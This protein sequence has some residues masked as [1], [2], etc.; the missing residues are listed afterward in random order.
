MTGQDRW[1]ALSSRLLLRRLIPHDPWR[2]HERCRLRRRAAGAFVPLHRLTLRALA[3]A[4]YD[5][6]DG[7]ATRSRGA[8]LDRC[9]ERAI[10]ELFEEQWTE[11][12]L[13]MPLDPLRDAPFYRLF[14]RATGLPLRWARPVCVSL[15]TLPRATRHAFFA[16]RFLRKSWNRHVAEGHGPP[17]R[18]ARRLCEARR[19]IRRALD[20]RGGEPLSGNRP[21]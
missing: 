15:N 17:E 6:R 20:E 8:W 9:V 16:V 12:D 5:A 11:E 1:I 2:L 18:V 4:A 21:P 19:A 13:G 14:T 3:R 7:S 10:H